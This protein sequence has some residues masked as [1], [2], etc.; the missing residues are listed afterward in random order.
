LRV[1]KKRVHGLYLLEADLALTGQ[2]VV[3][4]FIAGR[5]QTCA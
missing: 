5:R 4:A 3:D 1:N 2:S